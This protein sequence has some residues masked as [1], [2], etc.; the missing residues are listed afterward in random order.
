MSKTRWLSLRPAGAPKASVGA[1]AC[2]RL[3]H[4]SAGLGQSAAWAA[5]ML[6][7]QT[8]LVVDTGGRAVAR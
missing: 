3:P 6:A 4:A 8:G 2:L 1:R 7:G 5:S